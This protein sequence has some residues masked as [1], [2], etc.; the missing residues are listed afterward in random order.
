MARQ[1][2]K[3]NKKPK[4]CEALIEEGPHKGMQCGQ[5]S[6]EWNALTPIVSYG[7][8]VIGWQCKR[9]HVTA[10]HALKYVYSCDA[11]GITGNGVKGQ[12]FQFYMPPNGWTWAFQGPLIGP[13]ACSKECW[14]N[15]QRAEDG[16][17]WIDWTWEQEEQATPKLRPEPMPIELPMPRQKPERKPRKSPLKDKIS[18]LETRITKLE[19]E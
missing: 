9:G 2:L 7:K 17:L 8:R 1:P 13:H 4:V 12:Q 6:P 16:R 15:V 19:T 3:E 10:R 14:E 5:Y 18:D 11:C